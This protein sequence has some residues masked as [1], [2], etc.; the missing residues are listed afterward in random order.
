PRLARSI[1]WSFENDLAVL[2]TPPSLCGAHHPE[3]TALLS[4]VVQR[5]YPIYPTDANFP[6]KVDV[7]KGSTVNAYAS[8]GGRIYIFDGLL[9]QVTSVEELA[10]V[11]AHEIEHVHHRDIIQG[12][13]VRMV[14]VGLLQSIFTNVHAVGPVIAK[15]M[16]NMS[17]T[18]EQE[19]EAD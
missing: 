11:L 13:V 4:K 18:R 17:F 9:K 12:V 5:L 10:G 16:L 14:N 6:L 8:L 2:A 19:S 15:M 1:P 3:S 7:I